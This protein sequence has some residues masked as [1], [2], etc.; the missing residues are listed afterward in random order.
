MA[1]RTLDMLSL[2]QRNILFVLFA[3]DIENS[4]EYFILLPNIPTLARNYYIFLHAP[5]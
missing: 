1:S 3:C 2:Y 5:V 4:I